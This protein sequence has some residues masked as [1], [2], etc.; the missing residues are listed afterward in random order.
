M[1]A[2]VNGKQESVQHLRGLQL[3][4]SLKRLLYIGSRDAL[5]SKM[6]NMGKIADAVRF[7][8]LQLPGSHV[9]R[10]VTPTDSSLEVS[11]CDFVLAA[12]HRLGTP[13]WAAAD[14]RKCGCGD[15]LLDTDHVNRCTAQLAPGVT[16]RHDVIVNALRYFVEDVVDAGKIEI[17]I[18][19]SIAC[20]SSFEDRNTERASV[21]PDISFTPTWGGSGERRGLAVDVTVSHAGCADVHAVARAFANGLTAAKACLREHNDFIDDGVDLSHGSR[22]R[23]RAANAASSGADG[24]QRPAKRARGAAAHIAAGSGLGVLTA[25]IKQKLDHAQADEDDKYAKKCAEV[26]WDFSA[27]VVDSYGA[28]HSSATNVLARLVRMCVEAGCVESEAQL[29]AMARE[30]VAVAVQRGTAVQIRRAKARS[31]GV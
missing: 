4:R 3:E 28:L 1:Q 20:N 11:D 8:A 21:I 15:L 16:E 27:F 23:R 29:T 13:M 24:A 12:M 26:G 5:L 2:Y 18:K 17:S 10:A 6:V 7:A 31:I 19:P 14:V 22:K 25:A 30:R 9:F